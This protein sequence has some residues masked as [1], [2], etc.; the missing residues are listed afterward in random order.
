MRNQR[1]FFR[2]LGRPYL[3]TL[4]VPL[5]SI[6][7]LVTMADATTDWAALRAALESAASWRTAALL[8]GLILGWSFAAG[9]AFAPVW[10]QP[11]IAFLVRQPLHHLQWVAFLSPSVALG[12]IPVAGIAWLAPRHVNGIVHYFDYLVLAWP[13]VL[14]ASYLG[15]DALLIVSASALL[16][17]GATLAA[18][19]YPAAA[20]AVPFAALAQMSLAVTPVRRQVARVNKRLQGSLA[21]SGIVATLVRRDLRYLL[22]QQRKKLSAL[23]LYAIVCALL[24]L[25][26]RINGAQRGSDALLSA[27]IVFTIAASP[28]YEILEAMKK[29]LGKELM[30]RRWPVSILQRSLALISLV[31]ALAGPGAVLILLA[32]S[33]MGPAHA[34]VY[35][36]FV[37][38][39]IAFT[40]ALFGNLL[41]MRRSANGLY[42]LL[43]TLHMVAFLVLPEWVYALLAIAILPPALLA[44]IRGLNRF[45]ST[46][47]LISIGRLA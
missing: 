27:C 1:I 20:Y 21:G 24:M 10:R 18:L 32:G 34:L 30:R 8:T 9:R 25:A 43:I 6:L 4:V 33:V 36:L 2:I 23:A 16:L 28:A 41:I 38:C 11:V 44:T 29:A 7:L 35:V 42:L 22:R 45:T 14:G 31:A 5:F 15:R 37:A 26:F 19:Y 40:T 13:I 39:F 47:E 12:L 3:R 17:F 46:T